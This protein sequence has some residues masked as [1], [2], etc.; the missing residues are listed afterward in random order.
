M[1]MQNWWW[2]V[3]CDRIES[4]V[5]NVGSGDSDVYPSLA[6][7]IQTH[8]ALLRSEPLPEAIGSSRFHHYW[9]HLLHRNVFIHL[10]ISNCMFLLLWW[11]RSVA[12]TSNFSSIRQYRKRYNPLITF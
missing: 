6:C 11:I 1:V 9:H 7:R 10:V 12:H 4:G 5:W 2:C 8:V 3:R